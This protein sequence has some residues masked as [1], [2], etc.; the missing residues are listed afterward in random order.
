[1]FIQYYSKS[2]FDRVDL[3]LDTLQ[4]SDQRIVVGVI[5]TNADGKYPVAGVFVHIKAA[6][7]ASSQFIF[8]ARS[9][10]FHRRYVSGKWNTWYEYTGI[11]W[12]QS[13]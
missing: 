3:D 1:M 12:T 9:K 11:E 7:F 2:R 5:T 6:S 4:D 10:I 13:T 8:A